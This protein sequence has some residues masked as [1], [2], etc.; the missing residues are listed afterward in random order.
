MVK[1]LL[2]NKLM[3]DIKWI[4]I[5]FYYVFYRGFYYVFHRGIVCCRRN[6][7]F[8][9]ISDI[10]FLD[11][12]CFFGTYTTLWVLTQYTT[13][14]KKFIKWTC[15]QNNVQYSASVPDKLSCHKTIVVSYHF[16]FLKWLKTVVTNHGFNFKFKAWWLRFWILLKMVKVVVT[17]GALTLIIYIYI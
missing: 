16:I 5:G 8:S 14:K 1:L 2:K 13:L 10:V 7:I 12:L 6:N 15:F 17:I 11:H 9:I 4:F 3:L